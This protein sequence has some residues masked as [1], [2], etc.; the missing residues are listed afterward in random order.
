LPGILL[1]G[2]TERQMIMKKIYQRCIICSNTRVCERFFQISFEAPALAAA[3]R[4]GQFVSIRVSDQLDP[5]FRRP[6]GIYRSSEGR[7]D[8]LIEIRGRGTDILSSRLPGETLDILGPLGRPFSMPSDDVRHVVLIGGGVGVAP[9]LAMAE[10]LK[11]N[12]RD[13]TLLY[14]ARTNEYCFDLS[15]FEEAGCRVHL[16]T[17]DGSV[18]T[19]G[20]VSELFKEIPL[21]GGK[22]MLYVCGPDP[23]MKSVQD[24][25]SAHG[26]DG[27]C[28]C[29]EVMACG[30]GACLGCVVS[31]RSGYK[32]A[33]HDGPVFDL[34]DV[35]FQ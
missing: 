24:F 31:T 34:Q 30:I 7:V 10:A 9:L 28:S 16:A 17:D 35:I 11:D 1:C 29:E 18:G 5:F 33:C 27:E 20:R 19:P 6:F 23:M 25:A 4:P 13:V 8:L 21:D 2:L 26:L 22:T 12:G 32:T 14:G 3:G 15:P